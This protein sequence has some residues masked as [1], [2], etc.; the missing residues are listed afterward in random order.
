MSPRIEKL[1]KLII[2]KIKNLVQAPENWREVFWVM[3][4]FQIL[5]PD[6]SVDS[7]LAKNESRD[8]L[9]QKLILLWV[10]FRLDLPTIS[11]LKI[12]ETYSKVF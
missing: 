9:T 10:E 12:L 11:R 1:G 2:R 7:I 8:T 4:F 5:S 3:E 6:N